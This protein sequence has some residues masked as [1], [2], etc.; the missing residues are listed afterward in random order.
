MRRASWSISIVSLV[1][2]SLAITGGTAFGGQ[3]GPL[4]V[5]YGALVGLAS[6]YA[7]VGLAIRARIW[8]RVPRLGSDGVETV[9]AHRVF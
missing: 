3:F 8:R 7:L 5:G 6:I 4:T 2:A 1:V 9:A